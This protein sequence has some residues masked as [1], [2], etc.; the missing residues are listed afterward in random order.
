M[1]ASP[2]SKRSQRGE[3]ATTKGHLYR[4]IGVSAYGRRSRTSRPTR[5]NAETPKQVTGVA[6]LPRCDLL[7][8][9]FYHAFSG[10]ERY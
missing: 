4:P 5:P 7:F 3:A 10:A 8:D 1:A 2:M 6:A 9:L